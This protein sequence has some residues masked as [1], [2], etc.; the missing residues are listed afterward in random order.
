MD[1][2]K[3]KIKVFTDL[4][5]W[6]EGH[7]LVLMIYDETSLFPQREFFALTNQMRR[8]VVSITSNIAEGFS[9]RSYKE[10]INFYC[11]AQGSNTEIQ[12]QLMVARDI[13]YLSKEKFDILTEKTVQVNKLLN[14]LIKKSKSI[15]NSSIPNS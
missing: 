11:I 14:G 1:D 7:G 5:A 8:A 4:E 12:N 6:R 13:G 2:A 3:N 9:R 15:L 10:K